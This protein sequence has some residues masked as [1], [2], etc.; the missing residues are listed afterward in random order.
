MKDAAKDRLRAGV[1]GCGQVGL[2][3][4]RAYLENP[5]VELVGLCDINEERLRA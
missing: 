4:A 5:A 1:I 3:H 2:I